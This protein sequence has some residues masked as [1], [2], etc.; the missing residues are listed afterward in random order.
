MTRKIEIIDKKKFVVAALNSDDKIFVVY[1]IALAKLT[2][3]P[4]SFSY[5]AQTASSISEET[6]ISNE[7]PTF[8]TS[9]L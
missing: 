4:I 8:L 9:F 2:T 7:F 1:I 3:M 6:R 5:Q